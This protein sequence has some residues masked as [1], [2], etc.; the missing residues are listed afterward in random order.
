MHT[1]TNIEIEI[2]GAAAVSGKREE[3]LTAGMVGATVSFFFDDSWKDLSRVAVFRSGSIVKD[4]LQWEGNTVQIPPEVLLP[5]MDLYVGV[6][7]RSADGAVVI[8]TVWVKASYVYPGAN[9]SG[10]PSTD[11]ALPVWAQIQ[12]MIGDLVQL[13]TADKSSLV[14]AINEALRSGGGAVDEDTVALLVEE[15]L[16]AHP[17]QGKPGMDGGYYTPNVMQSEDGEATIGW[18]ASREGM[19]E[20]AEKTLTLPAGQSGKSAYQY[21]LDG[22]Y[23]GTEEEFTEKMAEEVPA[24][25]ESWDYEKTIVVAEEV[26]SISV[27]TLDDGTPLALRKIEISAIVGTTEDSKRTFIV[28]TD[29]PTNWSNGCV[30]VTSGVTNI[31]AGTATMCRITGQV[32]DGIADAEYGIIS[33]ARYVNYYNEAMTMSR[34]NIGIN[35]GANGYTPYPNKATCFNQV[36]IRTS[37]GYFAVGST[38]VIKGVKA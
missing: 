28:N 24:G 12:A 37:A 31:K 27:T 22:G 26:A 32:K 3:L 17:A 38:V 8:P 5:D 30:N 6:E 16:V 7:G 19:P 18:E 29:L 15:Y 25:G 9:A 33:P 20:V 34:K 1:V 36:V 35:Y 21:A 4:Q 13:G 10:D 23:T 14:A 11:P 2:N